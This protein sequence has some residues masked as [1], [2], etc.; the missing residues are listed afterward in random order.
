LYLTC[1]DPIS[2]Q[3]KSTHTLNPLFPAVTPPSPS[4]HL[5]LHFTT[6]ALL[7]L[8]S[9]LAPLLLVPSPVH[10]AALQDALGS[11]ESTI[12]AAGPLGPLLFILAYAGAAVVLVPASA[13][14]I[15]A[16]FLFGPVLGTG[17]V[18]VAS[19]AGAAAAFLIGRYLARPA[20]RARVEGD[21]RF[22]AVDAAIGKEGAKIVLLLRLSPLFPYSLLNYALSLTAIEFGPYVGASWAGML[23]GTVA[24]VALGGAGKAAAESATGGG[25]GALQ[26]GVY[27]LGE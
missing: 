6:K 20:V 14:T 10:A 17:V 15:L 12:A 2:L 27:A 26:L 19:T 9:V 16:G 23:P 21:P 18:S 5:T 4:T 24:Y 25:P 3:L 8:S 13:L 7:P 22:A 1:L 11:L